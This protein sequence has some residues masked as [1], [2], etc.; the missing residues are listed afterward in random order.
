[1]ATAAVPTSNDILAITCS[2]ES[3]GPLFYPGLCVKNDL[4]QGAMNRKI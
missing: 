2:L 4:C 1:M 3:G